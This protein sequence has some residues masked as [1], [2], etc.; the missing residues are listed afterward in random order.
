MNICIVGTGASGWMACNILKNLYFIDTI[1]VIES[2]HIPSIGVGEST[3][4]SFN[5]FLIENNLLSDF[6]IE[7]DA[8]VKYGVYYKNWSK[9]D[10]IHL[11]QD[12][13]IYDNYNTNEFEYGNLLL[14]KSTKVHIH[15]L[16]GYELWNFIKNNE[17]SLDSLLY[18]HSWHFDAG[19]FINFIK[20]KT[21]TDSKIKLINDTIVDCKFTQ[22]GDINYIIG[23]SN[24]RYYSDYFINC[25][26]D[27]NSN[28]KVFNIEYISLSNFLL[29][30]KAI[31]YPLE[32][33]NKKIEFHPYTVAKTMNNGWRWITPTQSRIGTG[34]VFSDNHISIDNAIDEFLIDIGD[35]TIIPRVVDFSPKI[36]VKPF[37][38]NNCT[39]GMSSGFLEP[40]DAPGLHISLEMISELKTL[41]EDKK[42][43]LSSYYNNITDSNKSMEDLYTFWGSFI[44]HQYKTCWRNDTKFWTDHKNVKCK[45]YDETITTMLSNTSEEEDNEEY[46]MIRFT[47]A[48]KDV[49]LKSTIKGVPFP[50][51]H[52]DV[53]KTI[54]HLEYIQNFNSKYIK[55]F[56]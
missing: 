47:T 48:A 6:V 37:K 31:V 49:K 36:N 29:T 12:F 19:K 33:K 43:N 32:Y 9:R 53:V 4:L 18:P 5:K 16:V 2:S 51:R 7:C 24:R 22:N 39:I 35:K 55:N 42:F 40:L 23:E 34:Y 52:K 10:F 30:N 46:L 20:N 14:N 17:I 1:T 44:L 8:A 13:E 27:N 28:Q 41:L 50:V 38:N 56:E 11:F 26:G 25:C 3:T 45:F 54:N 21:I 15:D